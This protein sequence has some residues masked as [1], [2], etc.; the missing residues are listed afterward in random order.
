LYHG[1]GT[2][3][4]CSAIGIAEENRKYM[5]QVGLS[6]QILVIASPNVQQNFR[7]QLF[8]ERKLKLEGGIWNLNTCVGNAIL[9]EVN[10][11]NLVG[12]PKDRIIAEVNSI[13]NKYYSFMG[14]IELANYIKR[15]T[16]VPEGAGYSA[17]EKKII[18]NKKINK[19]FDNRLIIIDEV[20]NIRISDDNK[21][22][23]S[24]TAGLLMDIARHSSNMRMLLLS[25]TPMYNNYKEIIWIT[26][27]INAVD[28][29]STIRE[30]DVFDKD[31]NFLPERK[32]KDGKVLESGRDILRRKLT[33]YVSYVRGENPYTFPY[34]IYPDTFSPD[35]SLKAIVDK[36]QYPT[37][38][39]NRREI[40]KPME[41]TPV[42][43]TSIGD[44][45]AKGYDFIMKHMRNRS[46]NTTN[47][48]GEEREMP[49][50]ENMDSF[51]YTYL[52]HPLESLDIVFPN[53][54]LDQ[55]PEPEPA[56]ASTEESPS[57]STDEYED[58]KNE[59][60]IKEF[61]GKKGLYN[62]MSCSIQRS[63][64]PMIYD[65]EYK[66]EILNDANH[67]RIFHFDNLSKY[68]NKIS[69]ICDC[70]RKSTGIVL[71]YSQYIEG[72]A[73][74]I[75]LALEEMGFGRYGSFSHVKSL[76][77]QPP[78]EP[79]DSL[80]MK[81]RSQFL[82]EKQ[83]GTITTEFQ[84]AKYVMIT[85]N[86]AF[87]PDNLADIK[88]VTNPN[89]KNGERVKVI[90]I[91]KAGSEGLDFKCIRQIHIME[92]W[93]NMSRIE[94]II[95]RG[96]RNFS[97]CL[98]E[99]EDRNV[100]IYLHATLPRNDEEPAD[101]YVYRYSEKKTLLIGKVTRMLKEIAVDCLLNIGQTNFT[102]DQ[103]LSLPQNKNMKIR[104]SSSSEPVDFNIGDRPYSEICDYMDNCNFTCSPTATIQEDDIITNTYNED[105]A[106]VN[107]SSIVK[108][109]RQLF[110]ENIF[111]KREHLINSI[112][113]IKKYPENQIDYAL[114]RFVNNKN[115]YVFDKYGRTGYL[116]NRDE[117]YAFQPI[118]MN[119]E[120]ASLFERSIPIDYKREHLEFELPKE[121]GIRVA[122]EKLADKSDSNNKEEIIQRYKTIIDNLKANFDLVEEYQQKKEDAEKMPAGE[123][124]WYAN[125]GFVYDLLIE[126]HSIDSDEITK[127]IVFHFL[128][129]IQIDERIVIVK[130]LYAEEI[131]LGGDIRFDNL[132]KE[133]FDNKIVTVRSYR[134]IILAYDN[135]ID[136]K[137]EK[138]RILIQDNENK[139]ILSIAEPLDRLAAIKSTIQFSLVQYSQMSRLVGF[140]QVFKN[141]I[142]V[143]KTMDMENKIKKGSKCSGEGK[144][145]VIK[146][147]NLICEEF[148]YTEDNT[149]N[150]ELIV[151]PG[152]C[153]ILEMLLRHYAV[154][155]KN[156]QVWFLDLEKAIFSKLVK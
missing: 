89:N 139:W 26:N 133:Y 152:L 62:V 153:V 18:R 16:K 72:S 116:V 7:L 99:F 111:Y 15:H 73:V 3:K 40:E 115:E 119:D 134:S 98:L 142:I 33:G 41:R 91:S 81:P 140:M 70:I 80:T 122:D 19:Y 127:F 124:D 39:M 37:M 69:T 121:K 108:R 25:A 66:P 144:K 11:T 90:I 141:N 10:P 126:N 136:A 30:D 42:F 130:C 38:Q 83:Q 106:K 46:Y 27:L 148:K 31:G 92:P 20:H 150:E 86:K 156:D 93:Y 79:I 113:I 138:Y 29:R 131:V 95:G 8:D 59:E 123:M 9:N 132:I 114:S 60:I 63:P 47:K 120:T 44:Y 74:P 149:E 55:L 88:Y 78:T 22:E 94:Q 103:L 52:L 154:V 143:F 56:S 101:L 67:G 50:F 87:S 14:Y 13:I 96:V 125:L 68:S 104:L 5:K 151:K 2:G 58:E 43:M 100:E 64:F 12:I 1:L 51:G 49:S 107:Y 145:D 6:Q 110:R 105:Y 102:I 112:N 84:Q 57:S 135:V 97:H 23:Q 17:E 4:T 65:F 117:I 128:D 82:A 34:R 118:E 109:I 146:K 48:F 24:K 75:A 54:F 32:T 36:S 71:I 61:V 53:K 21:G 35:N 137:N 147:L 155:K 129:S 28:K 77:K 45:Q 85:G 76:F